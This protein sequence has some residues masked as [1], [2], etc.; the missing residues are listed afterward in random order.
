MSYQRGSLKKLPRKGGETWVLRYRVTTADEKRVE[1]IMP[2][3]L[4]RD[5]PKEKDAW[6]EVN[7]LGLLVRINDDSVDGRI[8]FDVLGEHYLKNDLGPDPFQQKTKGPSLNTH[9]IVR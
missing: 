2:V 6:R 9:Q 1:H 8:R 7:R 3:G 4:V 5:F